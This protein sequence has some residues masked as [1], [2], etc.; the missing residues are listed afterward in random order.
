MYEGGQVIGNT[1]LG[2]P[3]T[4]HVLLTHSEFKEKYLPFK[5]TGI[6]FDF[7]WSAAVT[8]LSMPRDW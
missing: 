6:L 4:P 1:G 7:S 3:W 5:V 2:E 8:V